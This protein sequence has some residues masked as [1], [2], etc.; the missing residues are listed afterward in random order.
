MQI[1][2]RTRT[3]CRHIARLLFS[4]LPH[5]QFRAYGVIYEMKNAVLDCNLFLYISAH[6]KKYKNCKALDM[7]FCMIVSCAKQ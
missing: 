3:F 7:Y 4:L 2:T 6:K 5:V 1:I